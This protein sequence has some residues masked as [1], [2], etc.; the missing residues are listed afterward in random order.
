MEAFI[1]RQKT[2][3]STSGCLANAIHRKCNGS[4]SRP[5][6]ASFLSAETPGDKPSLWNEC[7]QTAARA[8][9]FAVVCLQAFQ[10]RVELGWHAVRL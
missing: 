1:C 5:A 9:I 4:N 7:A 6:F 3:K 2:N 10:S 8:L